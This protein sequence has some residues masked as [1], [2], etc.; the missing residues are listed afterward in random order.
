LSDACTPERIKRRTLTGTI[1]IILISAIVA[2]SL[3]AVCGGGAG[4]ILM[5]V[6]GFYVS[7]AQVPAALSI[8][9]AFSS[10]SRVVL[11]WWN[12]RWDI[13]KWFVPAALPAVILGAMLLRYINPL[14]LEVVMGI[15]LIGNLPE[16]L[17][18]RKNDDPT[19]GSKWLLLL[20]GIL[21]GFLSGLTGAVGL[22]FNRFYLKYGL[23]KEEIVATRAANEITLHIVKLVLYAFFGL[24]KNDV[25]VIGLTVAIAGVISSWIMKYGL[26]FI[27]EVLFRKVGYGAM[28]LSGVMMLTQSSAGIFNQNNAAI[29]WEPVAKGVESKLQWQESQLAIE[30]E[31]NEGLEYE[32]KIDLDELPAT[33]K[34]SVLSH[35]NGADRV[36]AEEVFG[37]GKHFYEA[38]YYKD[39]K[40][41]EKLE[42]EG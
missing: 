5:P 13:V 30:F 27:S 12:I 11:F 42:F 9:T 37:V 7:A 35:S 3:S 20:I 25:I 36:I 15:F 40:L 18:K 10:S 34:D 31:Y 38:Y 23:S 6:L 17:R 28:V 39:G 1:L 29:T 2:Y 14:Y 16:L 4:L 22:L 19:S 21:A 33:I 32:M 24:L 41:I 26:R 8:G